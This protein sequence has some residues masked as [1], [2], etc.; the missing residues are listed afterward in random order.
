MSA[1]LS[2]AP[3]CPK[4]CLT[5]ELSVGDTQASST[6]AS[7]KWNT[8]TIHKLGL[9]KFTTSHRRHQNH[10]SVLHTKGRSVGSSLVKGGIN[11]R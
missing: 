10:W 7:R 5:S 1:N 2:L 3:N 11:P 6:Y 8:C 9:G 4:P